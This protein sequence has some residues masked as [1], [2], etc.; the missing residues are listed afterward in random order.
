[1][2]KPSVQ[3]ILDL[4]R[5]SPA[6]FKMAFA[7]ARMIAPKDKVRKASQEI[8]ILQRGPVSAKLVSETEENI[9]YCMST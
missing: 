5:S 6:G 9:N 7:A 8:P 4:E 2:L 3:L 1:M